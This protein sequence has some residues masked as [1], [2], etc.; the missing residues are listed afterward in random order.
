[1]ALIKDVLSSMINIQND[2]ISAVKYNYQT[3]LTLTD[4]IN[5]LSGS[6]DTINNDTL[7]LYVTNAS[8]GTLL[9]ENYLNINQIEQRIDTVI[10]TKTQTFALKT[11]I[12][13]KISD[14]IN[15]SGFATSI[16]LGDYALKT[17]LFNKDYNEL[18]NKPTIPTKVSDLTNDVGYL[19]SYTESDPIYAAQ[20][21]QFVLKTE[22]P[23]I[24]LIE[25]MMIELTEVRE[26]M[27][28]IES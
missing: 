16:T 3:S 27:D 28:A 7:S 5:F 4:S 8:L 25:Q 24:E 18:N 17:D 6:I 1:M 14:L 26:I 21:G 15:D 22:I 2:T 13:T 19:I 20:S 10:S 11:E 23:T 9:S 12:P